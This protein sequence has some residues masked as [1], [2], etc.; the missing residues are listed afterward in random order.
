MDPYDSARIERNWIQSRLYLPL[1]G[2][3]L[4]LMIYPKFSSV[5]LVVVSQMYWVPQIFLDA[6]K[7]H[8]SPLSVKFILGVSICRLV[9]PLYMYGCPQS[10]F[11]DEFIP[12]PPGHSGFVVFLL[13]FVQIV[14]V[15]LM[16][17]QRRYGP[18]WFVP[19]MCLPNVYNYYRRVEL[20]EEFGVP[21]CVVCMGEIDLKE[22][23]K[24]TVITPCSHLFHADCLQQWIDIGKMECPICR[25]ELPPIT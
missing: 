10:I 2:S 25:R 14:Q 19:W 4:M 16:L 13:V 11:N 21:E 9:L 5:P 23:R 6:S 20:D 3:L 1:I 12:R 18:R 8:K 17:T 24:N 15:G 22:N 7:G